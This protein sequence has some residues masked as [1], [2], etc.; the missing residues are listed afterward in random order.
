MFSE[1]CLANRKK[2]EFLFTAGKNIVNQQGSELETDSE[3]KRP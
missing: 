1:L 3:Q 2:L